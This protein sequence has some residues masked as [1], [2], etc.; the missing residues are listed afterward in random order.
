VAIL[1]IFQDTRRLGTC[2]SC[3]API[4]WAA[5]VSG[6]RMPFDAPIVVV[7]AQDEFLAGG[8][9]IEDVDTTTTVSHFAT[10]PQATQW[11]RR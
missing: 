2:R 8:R 3:G 6:S 7:R 1:R 11:R 10:C 5:L 4:E 9:T